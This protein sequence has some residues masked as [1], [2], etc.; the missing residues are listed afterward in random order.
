[1]VGRGKVHEIPDD[2]RRSQIPAKLLLTNLRAI[3]V[4]IYLYF[5]IAD[6]ISYYLRL[7]LIVLLS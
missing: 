4:E 7:G 2:S 6:L 5:E 1:M 3:S